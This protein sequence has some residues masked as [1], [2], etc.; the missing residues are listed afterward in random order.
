M[1]QAASGLFLLRCV[2][3]KKLTNLMVGS[4]KSEP[5]IYSMHSH[6]EIR[7]TRIAP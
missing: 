6:S 1:G 4:F 5:L 7:A 3:C 2:R